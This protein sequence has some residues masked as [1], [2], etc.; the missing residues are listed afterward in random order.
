MWD[1]YYFKLFS[2]SF[3]GFL[4]SVRVQNREIVRSQSKSWDL[5][6]LDTPIPPITIVI[7]AR[8]FVT[9]CMESPTWCTSV[10]GIGSVRNAVSSLVWVPKL[11]SKDLW[12]HRDWRAGWRPW[13]AYLSLVQTPNLSNVELRGRTFT[14]RLCAHGVV[15]L[16]VLYCS[17]SSRD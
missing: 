11:G 17:P 12:S 13:R 2:F 1:F 10:H 5:P 8:I 16:R 4:F 3:L 9:P 14:L 15:F 6:C 7:F